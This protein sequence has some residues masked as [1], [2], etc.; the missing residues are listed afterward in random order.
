[1]PQGAGAVHQERLAGGPVEAAFRRRIQQCERAGSGQGLRPCATQEFVVNSYTNVF[2]GENVNP[3]D[4]SYKAYG[5]V[6]S[7]LATNIQLDW[8][9][10][11]LDGALV[12]ADK[13][14]VIANAGCT[15]TM[16]DATLVSVGEDVLWNNVG[17]AAFTV[18]DYAGNVIITVQPAIQ[19]Y[20]YLVDNSTQAGTWH[21]T[22]FGAG[23]STANAASLAGMGMRANVSRLDQNLLTD[24]P[25]ST[26]NQTLTAAD[27]AKVFRHTGGAS[28]HVFNLASSLGP[29]PM[30]SNGWFVVEINA[31]TGNLVLTPT[32]PDL[33]DGNASKTL[34]PNESCVIYCYGTGF[35][36]MGY[37]RAISTSVSGIGIDAAG[38][39][40]D[41]V[42]SAAQIAAQVQDFTGTLTGNRNIVYGDVTGYWF[43]YNHTANSGANTFNLVFKGGAAD[44][45]PVSVP[46]GNFSILRSQGGQLDIALTAGLGSVTSIA[47][48]AGEITGGN[49]TPITLTGTLGLADMPTGTGNLTPG[50]Y[51]TPIAVPKFRVDAKG[52]VANVVDTAISILAVQIAD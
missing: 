28:T 32:A 18:Y 16:P 6:A 41:I 35:A 15:I 31:G 37:G 36:T 48:T 33:I 49:P 43:I 9:F 47:T 38:A 29:T 7:P 34:G 3:A 8:P 22:Q 4:L 46:Q 13:I 27:R 21:I 10:E 50:T 30:D 42:L 12:V 5:T 44:S 40:T 14:D 1:M 11:A 17:A 45:T 20:T 2:G 39:T 52:R 26:G 23:T 51:G 25:R 24:L 19:W